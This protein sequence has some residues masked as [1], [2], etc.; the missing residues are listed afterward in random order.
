MELDLIQKLGLEN[1]EFFKNDTT[2]TKGFKFWKNLAQIH[3]QRTV[4]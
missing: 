4:T 3:T 1:L 2:R